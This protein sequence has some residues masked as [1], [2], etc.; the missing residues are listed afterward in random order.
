MRRRLVRLEVAIA[1]G[2]LVAAFGTAP[3]LADRGPTAPEATAIRAASIAAKSTTGWKV[4]R[5]RVST[6]D[7][8]Y[9][10]AG[11]HHPKTGVG[12]LDVLRRSPRKWKVIF[13]GTDFPCSIA[14]RR[15]LRDLRI[16]CYQ[17]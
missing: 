17:E 13:T 8:R 12:G 9:A 3:G 6:A 2:A 16:P 10:T 7:R 14:P 5:I 11:V 15:V 1:A 4:I